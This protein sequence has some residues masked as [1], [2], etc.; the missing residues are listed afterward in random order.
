MTVSPAPSP[1]RKPL[2]QKNQPR[3]NRDL[4]HRPPPHSPLIFLL[5]TVAAADAP[6]PAAPPAGK[7]D[8]AALPAKVAADVEAAM[9]LAETVG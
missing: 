7:A 5:M 8:A 2:L 3:P 6:A 9:Q 4:R 1:A